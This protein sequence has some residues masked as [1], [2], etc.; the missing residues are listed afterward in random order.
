[1]K[2][3][4]QVFMCE[5][6]HFSDIYES[7]VWDRGRANVYIENAETRWYSEYLKHSKAWLK[8]SINGLSDFNS[9]SV[10]LS[11]KYGEITSL[12]ESGYTLQVK[13]EMKDTSIYIGRIVVNSP[14]DGQG[15]LT[16]TDKLLGSIMPSQFDYGTVF[17]KSVIQNGSNTYYF[18]VYNGHVI[19]DTYN[20]PRI[21]SDNGMATYFKEKAKQIRSEGIENCDVIFA[22][23]T[24]N[25]ELIT[26]FDIN[27]VKETVVFYEP[28]NVWSHFASHTPNGYAFLGDTLLAVSDNKLWLHNSGVRN[29]F[30]GTQYES[31]VRLVFNAA[32]IKNKVYKSMYIKS[33]G[34]WRPEL[35]DVK[36]LNEDGT[37]RM[38]SYL[39][40]SKFVRKED[41]EF[42]TFLRDMGGPYNQYKLIN[43]ERLR[44]R[45]I[46]LNLRNNST[47]KQW[48][49]IVTVDSITSEY[50]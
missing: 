16:T 4:G 19:R 24:T 1:M 13:Q 26:T 25:N 22:F 23:D 28:E 39:P 35:G 6:A 27:G 17:P 48:L 37:E 43:G 36:I 38:T 40:G 5:D 32:S 21:I 31:V 45:F 9:E 47:V 41:G 33:L 3:G 46:V 12:N 10:N 11:G 50:S 20:G 2:N 15:Q 34:E 30:Y 14:S 29:H 49:G 7:A 8:D 18:D 42:A 44:G